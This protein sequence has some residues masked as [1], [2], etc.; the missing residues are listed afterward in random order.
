MEHFNDVRNIENPQIII[1]VASPEGKKAI[2][3]QLGN[4]G[5]KPVDDFWFFN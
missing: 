2:A 5:K 1:V 3:E 4:W